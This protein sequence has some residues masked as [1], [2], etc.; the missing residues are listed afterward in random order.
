MQ[1]RLEA[2]QAQAPGKP[3]CHCSILDLVAFSVSAVLQD[4]V[5]LCWQRQQGC[6]SSEQDL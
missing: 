1:H 6:A 3:A 2:G 5:A 4:G